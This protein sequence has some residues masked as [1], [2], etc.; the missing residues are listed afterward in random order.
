MLICCTSDKGPGNGRNNHARYAVYNYSSDYL[1]RCIL[2]SARR[3]RVRFRWPA[4]FGQRGA[5][6]DRDFRFGV[7]LA[8]QPAGPGRAVL[9]PDRLEHYAQRTQMSAMGGMAGRLDA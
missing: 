7:W 9:R 5:V 6:G 8:W 2:L 1:L 3:I 4:R